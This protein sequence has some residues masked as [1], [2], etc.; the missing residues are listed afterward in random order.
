LF[1]STCIKFFLVTIVLL[2]TG[3]I[4]SIIL[5][6][7]EKPGEFGNLASVPD[8]P[9]PNNLQDYKEEIKHLQQEHKEAEDI[10]KNIRADYILTEPKKASERVN[11]R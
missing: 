9:A 11:K 2:L 3:C 4:G 5:F 10:N 8:R 7:D 6:G 1:S